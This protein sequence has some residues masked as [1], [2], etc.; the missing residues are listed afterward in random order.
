VGNFDGGVTLHG[1]LFF[2]I[3]AACPRFGS[4]QYALRV[5]ESIGLRDL[6]EVVFAVDD[7]LPACKPEP[8]AF[9]KVF[10]TLG[11]RAE[12]CVMIEDSM[13]NVR[14]AKEL[15]MRTVLITGKGDHL[16]DGGQNLGKGDDLP[17][18]DDPAVDVAIRTVGE[19]KARLPGLWATPAVFS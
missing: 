15:G 13:K 19:L 7:V 11:V 2:V 18:A 17:Q 1:L 4:R 10:A 8:A 3:T 5:L 14:A 6:F 9:E 12:N 16:T